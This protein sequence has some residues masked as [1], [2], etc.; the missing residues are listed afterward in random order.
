MTSSLRKKPVN[1]TYDE[2]KLL[3]ELALKYISFGNAE[4]AKRCLEK[5]GQARSKSVG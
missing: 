2:R 3:I 4:S 5:A 1:I